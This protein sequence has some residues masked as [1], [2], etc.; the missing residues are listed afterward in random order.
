MKR[1]AFILLVLSMNFYVDA[2]QHDA[3]YL[4]WEKNHQQQLKSDQQKVNQKLQALERRFGKKPNIIYILA[5]DLGWGELGC[6]LVLGR[7]VKKYIHN[8]F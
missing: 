7:K 6:Y 8:T 5:D 1:V 3:Q 4:I 2:V